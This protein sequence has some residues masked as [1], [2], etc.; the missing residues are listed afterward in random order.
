[1]VKKATASQPTLNLRSVANNLSTAGGDL[2]VAEMNLGD[3]STIFKAIVAC[4]TSG[5]LAHSLADF[6]A[7]LCLDAEGE[8]QCA[9]DTCNELAESLYERVSESGVNDGK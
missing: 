4:T 1:M 9:K 2:S 8:A 7:R 3:A 6:G 5:T